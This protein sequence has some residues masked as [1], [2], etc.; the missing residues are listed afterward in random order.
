MFGEIWTIPMAR[1]SWLEVLG[2]KPRGQVWE[3]EAVWGMDGVRGTRD[4]FPPRNPPSHCCSLRASLLLL[5]SRETTGCPWTHRN[6][7]ASNCPRP[8]EESSFHSPIYKGTWD[9]PCNLTEPQS[10]LW[11]LGCE[12]QTRG[13]TGSSLQTVSAIKCH[14][15]TNA[16]LSK[17]FREI[18]AHVLSWQ[19]LPIRRKACGPSSHTSADS[20]GSFIKSL[21]FLQK[22]AWRHSCATESET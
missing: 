8:G 21:F 20:W 6:A 15:S 11:K 14:T 17:C 18:T 1:V 5:Y 2:N 10:P 3:W 7:S 4:S 12:N 16:S 9:K 13:C 19:T 22:G